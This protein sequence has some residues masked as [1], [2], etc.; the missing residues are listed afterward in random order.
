VI[1]HIRDPETITPG[2][3]KPPPGG[4]RESQARSVISYLQRVRA[5]GLAPSTVDYKPGILVYGAW[6]AGCHIIDGEGV[7]TGP[8]LTQIGEKHDAKWLQS[9]IADPEAIKADAD[10][11]AFGDRLSPDEL[12]AV[13]DFL[14]ARKHRP[15]GRSN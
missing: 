11:P 5:G 4:M 6:C 12:K 8:D 15:G 3:R 7:K 9:W 2:S 14:A 10:M 1:A 13:A